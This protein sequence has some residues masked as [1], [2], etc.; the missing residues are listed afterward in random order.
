MLRPCDGHEVVDLIVQRIVVA[1]MDLVALGDRT[2]VILPDFTVQGVHAPCSIRRA[3]IVVSP[4]GRVRRIGITPEPNA[5]VDNGFS[6]TSRYGGACGLSS[7][8]SASLAFNKLAAKR[9]L[10]AY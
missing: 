3:G 5:F 7:V 2:V 4:V 6:H 9:T 10:T 8:D 1:M